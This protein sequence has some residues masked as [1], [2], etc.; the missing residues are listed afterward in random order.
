MRAK[1]WGVRGSLPAPYPPSYLEKKIRG[2]LSDFKDYLD[3]GGKEVDGFLSSIEPYRFKGFGG[4]TACVE[5][6][7]AKS[8]VIIDGGSGIRRLGEQMMLGPAGLG[9]AKISIVMTHF[10]WDHLIGLPFFNPIFVPGNEVQF[11]A[12][13]DDLEERIR[14]IFRKP[15]F[16]VSYEDLA[17]NISFHKLEARKPNLFGD[18][19]IAPY[20]LDHP[21]PCWGLRVEGDGRSLAYCV[22]TECQRSS[23]AELGEDLP[24]YKNANVMLFDAQYSFLEA[25][26]KVDWGHASAPVGIDLAMRENVERIYFVHHDPAASDERIIKFQQQTHDYIEHI[27]ELAKK[28]GEVLPDVDWSFAPE[29]LTIEI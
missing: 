9:R 1:L 14:A 8:Q 13:Q 12:V 2:L 11:F 21:D 15:N 20:L 24:L 27:R 25:A 17:A 22:D 16:P 18:I 10:H 26:E 19:C 7:T 29:G 3:S 23:E 28:R 6:T 5:F 4:H